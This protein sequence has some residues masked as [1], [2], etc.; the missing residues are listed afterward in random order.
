MRSVDWDRAAEKVLDIACELQQIPAPTFHEDRRATRV[1]EWFQAS[2]L[3]Q[4]ARDS[5]GNILGC[6]KDSGN[7]QALVITAHMDTV[8]P[9]NYPLTLERTAGRIAGPGIGDNALGL[10]AVMCLPELLK[11]T[12]V[13]P[14]G[15]LWLVGTTGEE[16]MGDLRGIRA[17]SG[18]FGSSGVGYVS[19]EGLGFGS[20]LHRGLGVERYRVNVNTR[21][22]HSWVDYGHPSAVHELAG[23]ASRL[24]GQ[25]LPRRPRS[26][27]N[28]GIIQGGTSVNSIAANAWMD[29]DLRSETAQGLADL[30]R[31]FMKLVESA[32]RKDV[33]FTA[34]KIGHRGAAEIPRDHPLVR[35]AARALSAENIMPH[36][37]IASTEAN[38]PLCRG[39]AA[40]TLGVTT[41]D[42][43]H[44]AEEYIEVGFIPKGLR[45]LVSVVA[46]AW[47]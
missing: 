23:L 40:V 4:I 2:G 39:Y 28:I 1:M 6:L 32:G 22:G 10:A 13:V 36:Y 20:I 21:G 8:F 42:R 5:T 16:G 38:E 18:R 26:T 46:N 34:E 15:S 17:I 37:D 24:A 3:E 30:T 45:Q 12:E 11:E 27:L 29:V 31:R 43:A 41:G 35:V 9:L 25:R 19:I 14:A 47:S 33:T 44:T 7:P